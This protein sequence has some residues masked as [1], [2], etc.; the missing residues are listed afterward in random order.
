M[1]HPRNGHISSPPVKNLGVLRWV[2]KN[3]FRNTF[4]SIV[5]ICVVLFLAWIVPAVFSWMFLDAV[6]FNGD[7][8]LC[9]SADGACWPF[10]REKARLILFGTYPYDQ[11]WRAAL[12]CLVVI[13]LVATLIVKRMKAKW[14]VLLWAAGS[15]VFVGLMFGNTMGLPAVQTV[16]WNGLPVFLLL[17]VFS[18]AAAFPLGILLALAR[19]QDDFQLLKNLAAGYIELIRGVPLLMVLFMGLFVLPMIMPR[20]FFLEPLFAILIALMLFHAAYFAEDIRGGLQTLELGQAEAADSLGL[21]YWPKVLLIVLPQALKQSLPAIFN[22]LIGGYK[23]TSLVIIVGIHDMISTAKMAYSD[24][25]WQR[26]GLEAYFF[27]G[28][29][30]FGSCWC[31]SAYGRRLERVR[32]NKVS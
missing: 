22:T 24:P 32:A 31:L 11:Q 1:L 7:E 29:W 3:L 28:I 10:M 16:K 20:G 13:G 26:Y 6:G 23:D 15:A 4:D 14:M 5:T 19:H 30:Y 2:R 17:S 21:S 9:R 12:A 27:V 18:L 8:A 25:G